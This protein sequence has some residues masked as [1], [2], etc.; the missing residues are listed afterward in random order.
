[1]CKKIDSES[2]RLK[3]TVWFYYRSS[4]AETDSQSRGGE[5]QFRRLNLTNLP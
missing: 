4:T 3:L 1:M 2:M 5:T